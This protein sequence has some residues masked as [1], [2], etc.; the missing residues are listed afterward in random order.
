MK[1]HNC[2]EEATCE[3]SI[4]AHICTCNAGFFGSG[5]TCS[6]DNECRDPNICS[7]EN[8]RCVNTFG[9]YKCQCEVGFQQNGDQC[10]PAPA[11]GS[12]AKKK[13][14]LQASCVAFGKNA[15][16]ICNK[17]FK[18]SGMHCEDENE[19]LLE[20]FEC[21]GNATCTNTPG[22]YN[23]NCPST[24][25]GD[26]K[27][28]QE[29]TACDASDCAQNADCIAK[30]ASLFECKCKEGFWGNGYQCTDKNECL[31][32]D[33]HGCST[34]ATCINSLGSYECNCDQGYEGDGK[35]CTDT[36]ECAAGTHNCHSGGF[37][38]N[39]PGSY[40]CKCRAGF[41]GKVVK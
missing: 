33:V 27:D 18:G 24:M 19:C 10:L 26:G 30:S 34:L 5:V 38:I 12:C 15:Q 31:K 13:C 6:D 29:S 36:D 41:K 21:H 37:C 3:N 14:H 8:M 20:T 17:G 4:G 22:G 39:T 28:C 16:C 9:S 11:A 35:L 7:G 32:R 23:C 25:I 40:K 2:H 1:T